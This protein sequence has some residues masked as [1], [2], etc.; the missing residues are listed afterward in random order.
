MKDKLSLED[1][2]TTI[3]SAFQIARKHWRRGQY[4]LGVSDSQNAEWENQIQRIHQ[5]ESQIKAMLQPV[6]K[7][8]KAKIICLC[9]STRFTE[10]MMIYQWELTKKGF[11]VVSWC[12]LPDSYFQGD[13]K[14]HIGDQEG[15]KEIVDEVH[16]RKID[17]A[18]EVHILNIG[19]YIGESTQNELNYAKE[20]GKII[21]FIEPQ[22][23]DEYVNM[24]CDYCNGS[25]V[26]FEVWEGEIQETIC[27]HCNGSG[28]IMRDP[29]NNM[30]KEKK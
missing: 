7:E 25:G 1:L 17:L 15:V 11:I 12:A 21:K 2:W 14:A 4:G 9:G 30:W 23:V 10:F 13:D 24:A 22:N 19:G 3:T 5:A 8:K 29:T 16:M 27:S 20:Q 28:E 18:D 6:S 26:I